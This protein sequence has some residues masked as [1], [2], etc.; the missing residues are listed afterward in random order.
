MNL[1]N[2]MLNEG[3]VGMSAHVYPHTIWLHLH[4]ILENIIL[5]KFLAEWI[6]LVI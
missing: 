6:S 1:K 4:N 5:E 3:Q 2:I